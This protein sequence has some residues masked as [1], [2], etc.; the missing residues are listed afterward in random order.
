L[1]RSSASNGTAITVLPG[2]ASAAF[3]AFAESFTARSNNAEKLGT[4]W[5]QLSKRCSE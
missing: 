3:I 5:M 1:R 2:L 4:A